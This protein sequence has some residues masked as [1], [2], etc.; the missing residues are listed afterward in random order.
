MTE[1]TTR[2]D[3]GLE[4]DSRYPDDAGVRKATER[5]DIATEAAL[6]R[7][8]T[9]TGGANQ[10]FPESEAEFQQQIDEADAT[11]EEEVDALYVNLLQDDEPAS[12]RE[13]SGHVEDELAE[14]RIARL[15]EVGPSAGE[16]GVTVSAPG[17][18]DTSF[19]IRRHHPD[20][21]RGRTESIVEGSVEEPRDE[22]LIE[23]EIDEGPGA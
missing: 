9:I 11:T 23:R 2:K 18:D 21:E 3:F 13:G 12:A 7:L 14:D 5:G 4:A 20:S 6:D 8:E 22:E 16:Q 17:R 1:H 10:D 19:A 15:T